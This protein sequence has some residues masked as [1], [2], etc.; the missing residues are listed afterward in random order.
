MQ[1]HHENTPL[2]VRPTIPQANDVFAK[3]LQK[4][5]PD[6]L[7]ST[8]ARKQRYQHET[9]AEHQQRMERY[10][11]SIQECHR[12][13]DEMVATVRQ[14]TQ[15]YLRKIHIATEQHSRLREQTILRNLET[16]LTDPHAATQP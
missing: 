5:E 16:A 3:M 1:T 8:T 7:L 4:V 11:K 6:F 14:Q 13:R 15:S 9:P 12:Q 2:I 10:Q